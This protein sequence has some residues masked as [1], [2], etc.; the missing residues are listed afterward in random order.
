MKIPRAALPALTLLL[1]LLP[2]LL[3]PASAHASTLPTCSGSFTS[4]VDITS[5]SQADGN[6]IIA[7]VETQALTGCFTG[8]RV[9]SGIQIVHADGTFE[10]HDTGTFTGTA[11]GRPG[12]VV[13]SGTSTGSGNS[14]SGQLAVGQG[15]GALAGLHAQGT[16]QPTITAPTTS[17][18]TYAV[19][20]HFGS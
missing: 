14:G 16:F 11:D 13:I 3:L 18:G 20:F 17:E 9:A 4:T 6:T 2:L 15:T 19:Q 1:P 5:V 8:T 7:G 12:T 10:A